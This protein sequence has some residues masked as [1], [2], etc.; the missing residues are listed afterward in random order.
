MEPENSVWVHSFETKES[1]EACQKILKCSE[2]SPEEPI[3][4]YIDSYGGS[5]YGMAG[6]ISTL[7]SIP[8]PI[9]TVAMG[10]AMSAG[11]ILLSHGD[12]RFVGPHA[13]IMVHEISAGFWGNV[14]DMGNENENIQQL[15]KYWM[16]LLAK[17]CGKSHKQL[18]AIFT[19]KREVYMGAKQ[20]VS[21][22]IADH[23]GVPKLEKHMVFQI[24]TAYKH[25][26]PKRAKQNFEE[27][28]AKPKAK[29]ATK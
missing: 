11:A 29:K 17:N 28:A 8:N 9:I 26:N 1:I 14:K 20:A 21:F 13:Q 22:G 3:V 25:R 5:V 18:D 15:N 2:R 7:D 27:S 12:L 16:N 19:S 10:K 24:Q 23:I 4:I 6:I